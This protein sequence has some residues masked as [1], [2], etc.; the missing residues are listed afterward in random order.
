MGDGRVAPPGVRCGGAHMSSRDARRPSAPASERTPSHAA[1][2]GFRTNTRPCRPM[3]DESPKRRDAPSLLR[4]QGRY[5]PQRHAE[6]LE[7]S[8]FL[9]R[10]GGGG[11]CGDAE[12][13]QG[14]GQGRNVAA[15][16][17][18]F[19]KGWWRKGSGGRRAV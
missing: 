11:G 9:G 8:S 18:R 4:R 6:V 1:G 12:R 14:Q 3:T 10:G 13:R 16:E 17:A 19:W 7:H 5:S 15:A 2:L